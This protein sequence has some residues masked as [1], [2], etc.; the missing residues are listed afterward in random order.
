MADI[1]VQDLIRQEASKA[2]V[3][4]ELAL[5]VAEQ[6][7]SF[8]PTAIGPQ[9]DTGE[10]A[11]GTFQLLPS[12]AKRLGVDPSD[13]VQNIRGGTKYLKEL[14]D[15]HQGDLNK[16]LAEYGGVKTDTKYVPGVLGRMGKFQSTQAPAAPPA[17]RTISE[18]VTDIGRSILEGFDPRTPTGRQNLAGGAGA[19]AATMLAPELALP[20]FAAR[21]VAI[22]VPIV[23]A[24]LGG[25]TA[26]AGEDIAAGGPPKLSSMKEAAQSQAGNEV[27]GQVG[28]TVVK[29]LSRRVAASSVS[30]RISQGL[31]DAI[32]RVGEHLKMQRPTVS[33]AQ[34]GRLVTGEVQGASKA[35]KDALGED[36][37]KAAATGPDIPTAPLKD[38]LDEL[39][40]QITPMPA[41]G[42]IPPQMVGGRM[43]SG[44][45]LQALAAS[46][47]QM[48]LTA[49][50][51]EHP[52]PAV[53]D[54][55]RE[56]IADHDT[57]PF[58]EAHKIKGLL[59]SVVTW[60]KAAKAKP[61]QLSKGFRQTLRSE[62]SG[63]QPYEQATEAYAPV[64]KLYKDFGADRL[65]AH[66]R[67]NPGEVVQK[68]TWKNPEGVKLLK[69]ITTLGGQTDDAFRAVRSAWTNEK[70][71][72]LGP[73]RMVTAIEKMEASNAGKEFIQQMY[74]D[75]AGATQW[76]NLKA[77]ATAL[78]S[79][80]ERAAE[81]SKTPLASATEPA[82][83]I[84]DIMLTASPHHTI[85][86]IGASS[87]LLFGRGTSGSQMLEWASHADARTQFLV[88]HVL[89]GPNP[90]MALADFM[91]WFEG[92]EGAPDKPMPSHDQGPPKPQA[93]P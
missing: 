13:P 75:P 65:A 93:R 39:A 66:I 85:G 86:K 5:A 6:E 3:P 29:G 49:L 11:V 40:Q 16:V 38:R 22:G 76:Q 41:H 70:L 61:E 62:M 27:L 63:H 52:L 42:Q 1:S 9:L 82:G 59:D 67:S 56:A 43:L 79:A 30:K 81:F 44:P 18:R 89:T 77:I 92:S 21:A 91:R 33:P 48:G 12:T 24:A 46:Q 71:I 57:I 32:D 50:P 26:Q 35:F 55:I 90:G 2:G 73:E 34:A 17:P 19:A 45:Q 74:G 37:E 64:A 4:P 53:L 31:S 20:A 23:G 10:S 72:A 69:D 58:S 84:R 25:A 14:L 83:V 7:S 88:K 87:R 28:G 36:V 47:P 68:I 78:Q 15:R 51:A 54:R 60:E 80:Q 8:N